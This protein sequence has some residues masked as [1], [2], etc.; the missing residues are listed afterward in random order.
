MYVA[1]ALVLSAGGM[2]SAW[3]VGVWKALRDYIAIAGA[4]TGIQH[5]FIVRHGE[6]WPELR[7]IIRQE[8]ADLLVVGTHGRHG[9]AKLFFGSIAEQIF[10]QADCPVLT[11]G[12]IRRHSFH[13]EKVLQ[14]REKCK[15]GGHRGM[16]LLA[17]RFSSQQLETG[18]GNGQGRRLYE[19]NEWSG[20]RDLNSRP[21]APQASALPG[22]ATSRW[23]PLPRTAAWGLTFKF[24]TS[25]RAGARAGNGGSLEEASHARDWRRQK[26]GPSLPH[27]IAPKTGALGAPAS[28]LR[29][30]IL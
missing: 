21:L 20:R 23:N 25:G 22:C 19:V 15:G 26:A 18:R 5:K 28:L 9:I 2:F 1:T 30:T 7:E 24:Y 8:S 3:E 6:L 16:G 14:T 10:R 13:R 17:R 12:H 4:L 27:P 11:S 29:M